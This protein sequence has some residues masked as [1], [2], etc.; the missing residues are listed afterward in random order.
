M[1]AASCALPS[2]SASG[3]EHPAAMASVAAS[4]ARRRK[5]LRFDSP[6]AVVAGVMI[7]CVSCPQRGSRETTNWLETAANLQKLR[8]E[9]ATLSLPRQQPHLLVEGS[10][11]TSPCS[12]RI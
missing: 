3:D 10:V 7:V 6:L 12:P 5:Q 2:V 1:Y 4:V 9:S 11:A 8:N